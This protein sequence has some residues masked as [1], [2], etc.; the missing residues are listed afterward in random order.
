MLYVNVQSAKITWHSN[1]WHVNCCNIIGETQMTFT[2]KNRLGITRA[3][4]RLNNS[5]VESN[6]NVI[7]REN[8]I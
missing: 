2:G 4:V 6:L 5:Q 8:D 1:I 3:Y 7:F